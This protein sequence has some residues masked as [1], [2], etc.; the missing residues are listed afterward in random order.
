MNV[1]SNEYRGYGIG[2]ALTKERLK[3]RQQPTIVNAWC[4]TGEPDSSLIFEKLNFKLLSKVENN[5]LEESKKVQND[6][7]CP[8]CGKICYCDSKIYILEEEYLN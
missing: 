6:N 5:W 1:V 8:D 4:R 3:I 2:T 7:F